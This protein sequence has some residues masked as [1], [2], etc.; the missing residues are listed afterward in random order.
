MEQTFA[1]R[2]EKTACFALPKTFF[3]DY[4]KQ[5][6]KGNTSLTKQKVF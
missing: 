1:A 6:G 5:N 4:F 2:K 3:K